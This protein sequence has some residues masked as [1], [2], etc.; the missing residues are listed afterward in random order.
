MPISL[1]AITIASVR[2]S[3]R[4]AGSDL[5]GELALV[6]E[7]DRPIICCAAPSQGAMFLE[8]AVPDDAGVA[9]L[10]SGSTGNPKA[11]ALTRS[12][13]IAAARAFRERYGAFTW[14][15]A[16]PKPYIAG[17]MVLVRGILDQEYGGDGVKYASSDLHD[18]DPGAGPEAISLVPTQLVRALADTE[19]TARLR[20]YSLIL[21]GGARLEPELASRARE[22]GLSIST[23]YGMSETC[24]GC[25]FD[26]QPLGGVQVELDGEQR[27]HLGGPMLFS[28]Y[29]GDEEAT[30]LALSQGRLRTNDRGE[31]VD[32]RLRIV[33]RFD[34]LVITGGVNVD[35]GQVNDLLRTQ[36]G[37]HLAVGVPDTEWGTRIVLATTSEADLAWWRER[38]GGQLATPALPKQLV[39]LARLPRLANGKI[40]RQQ[41]IKIARKVGQGR[42]EHS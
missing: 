17:V 15:L 35:L 26:G 30:R 19:V 2:T 32:D 16:L 33:G 41:I 4:L 21:I 6:L 20:D 40:D 9:V 8:C 31:W 11:V 29:L 38:L 37:E 18:V 10:T 24:G 1:V 12:A 25:V 28:G 14:T 7:G 34:D 39:R 3:W 23:S 27:V 13:I 36:A 42:G 5:L 22:A